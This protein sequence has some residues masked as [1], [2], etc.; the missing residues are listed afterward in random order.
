MARIQRFVAVVTLECFFGVTIGQY[1]MAETPRSAGILAQYALP[2]AG[3][4]ATAIAARTASQMVTPEEGG[5][6]M[7]DGA[8]IKIPAGAVGKPMRITISALSM[9]AMPGD[10]MANITAGAKAYRFEP[11]GTRFLKPVSVSLPFDKEI[12]GSETALSNTFTYF[13]NDTAL[14][15]ERLKRLFL[16]R[17]TAVV[18]SETTHFTDMINATLKLPEGPSPIQF[19]V[20]SIKN[21]Q[22][23]DPSAGVPKVEGLEAQSQG[24]AAFQIALRLPEGRGG[25]TPKLA[26]SYSSELPN[27]W[28]G[29]G[30]DISVPSIVI[31]TKFGLPRY[32]GTDTYVLGGDELVAVGTEGGATRYRPLKESAFQRIL[33][34]NTG[35]ENFWEVT[36][37]TGAVSEYGR[38]EGWIGPARADRSRTYTWYLTKSRDAFGNTIEYSY[39]YDID[40]AYT[41][42]SEIRYSGFEGSGAPETGAYH[43]SFS[44]ED[45][46][47]RRSDSRGTFASKLAHR[48]SGVDI[49]YENQRIRSYAP[50]YTQ[51]Q[52]GQTQLAG[53][54]ERDG[55]GN[56][57]YTYTFDYY[58]LDGYNDGYMAF[59]EEEDWQTPDSGRTLATTANSSVGGNL[60]TGLQFFI[61]LPFVGTIE[62]ASFGITGGYTYSTTSS[63][64]SLVDINGDGLPDMVWRSGSTLQSYL[65]GNGAFMNPFGVSGMGDAMDRETQNTL[66]IGTTAGI[67]AIS[68]SLNYQYTWT[69][70]NTSFTDMNADG[71]IDFVTKNGMQFGLNNGLVQPGAMSFVSTPLIMTG[72]A[73][74]QAPDPRQDSFE[75]AYYKQEP[76]RK[77]RAYRSGTVEVDQTARLM[78]GNSVSQDG[79]ALNTYSEGGV[80]AIALGSGTQNGA[81]T[82]SYNVDR[83]DPLYFHMDTGGLERGDETEWKVIIRYTSVRPFEALADCAEFFPP[84]GS[85]DQLPFN[86]NRLNPI[87]DS[88]YED[89]HWVYSLKTG[90]R[91]LADGVLAPVY[92]ALMEHACFVPR[93]ISR[94]DMDRLIAECADEPYELVSVQGE[95][96]SVPAVN[97]MLSGYRFVNETQTLYRV[98]G[99]GDALVMSQMAEEFTAEELGRIGSSRLLDGTRVVPKPAGGQYTATRHAAVTPA[100][101]TILDSDQAAVAGET[102]W[103]QGILM[104]ALWSG[105]SAPVVLETR[106]LRE[107]GGL[108]KLYIRDGNGEREQTPADLSV[109]NEGADGLVV[110]YTESGVLRTFHLSGRTSLLQAMCRAAYEGPLSGIVMADETLSTY[111]YE[112][113]PAASFAS[114]LTALAATDRTFMSS[115]YSINGDVYELNASLSTADFQ[116]VLR[117]LE[118]LAT[119]AGSLFD[120]FAGDP[121]AA[122]RFIRMTQAEYDSFMSGRDPQFSAYFDSYVENLI[123]YRYQKRDLAAADRTALHQAMYEFRRDAELFPYYTM[124]VLTG[125][126][127]LKSGLS[128]GDLVKVGNTVHGAGLSAYTGM[129][130]SLTY[131]SNI[132]LPVARTTLPDGASEESDAPRGSLA[133]V[134]AGADTCVVDLLRFDSQERTYIEP[135]YLHVFNTETDYSTQGLTRNVDL[136]V[137]DP[138]KLCNGENEI[139][140]GGVQGWYYG[141]WTGYY[142]WNASQLGKIPPKPAENQTPAP[143]Y[144]NAMDPNLQNGSA[145]ISTDGKGTGLP[146]PSDAWIGKV[147]S[148]QEPVMDDGGVTT[149]QTYTY[150]AFIGRQA[151]HASRNGGEAYYNIPVNT[152]GGASGSLPYIR[153]SSSDAVDVNGGVSVGVFGGNITFNSGSSWQYQSLMDLNGDRYPDLVDFGNCNGSFSLRPGTGSGFGPSIGM[154]TPF[155]HISFSKNSTYGFG[156]SLGSASG[157]ITTAYDDKGKPYFTTVKE[158]GAGMSMGINGTIG[159]SYQTEGFFD[160]NGD[161]LPDHVSRDGTGG[162]LVALNT[163]TAAFSS[164]ILDWGGGMTGVPNLFTSISELMTQ[165]SGLNHT[166]TGSFGAN[167]GLTVDGAVVGVGASAG[168]TATVSQTYAGLVDVNGDGLPDQVVKLKDD[169]YFRVRFNLGDCFASDTVK[170]YRPEWKNYDPNAL[171]QAVE[172]DLGT[173]GDNITGVSLPD[174]A[175][176]TDYPGGLPADSQNPVSA[177]M[178]PLRVD[179]VLNYSSGMSFNLGGSLTVRICFTLLALTIKAGV[180]GSWA[181]TSTTIQFNDI[182]GDGLPDHIMKLP[183]EQFIRVKP[184]AMGKVGLLS[185]VHLPQG[186]HYELEYARVGNT[187]DMPQSKWVLSKVT[188]DAGGT[189]PADRGADSYEVSYE[190]GNGYYSRTDREFWGFDLVRTILADQ[191]RQA[192]YYHNR[193]YATRGME[194]KREAWGSSANGPAPL[195]SMSLTDVETEPLEYYDQKGRQAMFPRPSAET[196]RLYDEASGS[197][198]ESRTRYGYTVAYGN[199]EDVWD[200]GDAAAGGDELSAHIEYADL[201]GYFKQHPASITIQG[202]SGA[203]LRK[204]EGQYGSHGELVGLTQYESPAVGRTWSIEHD[205]YGNLSSIRDPR[206]SAVSWEYDVEVH[207]HI[208]T[209]TSSNPLLGGASYSSHST[210]D[211]GLGAE[212]ERVDMTGEAMSFTYDSHARMTEVRSPYDTGSLPSV[213]YQYFTSS[214]PWYAVTQ[215]KVSF[216]PADH[217]ALST[218]ISVDGLGRVLQTAKQGEVRREGSS[219]AG[220]NVSGAVCYDA[221]E[222]TVAEGQPVFMEGAGLP[223]LATLLRPTLKAYDHL[224]RVTSIMLPGGASSA[225]SYFIRNGRQVEKTIDPKGNVAEKVI[226]A[227]GNTV[228]ANRL[229]AAEGLLTGASYEYD[230]LGQILTVLD[231]NG[232]AV[233]SA[234]DMMGRRVRLESP[235]TGIVEYEFDASGNVARKTDSVTRKRGQSIRYEYDGLNRLVKVDYPKSPD[236]LYTYGA[237][238]AEHGGAGRIIRR[239]DE[240]GSVSFR[241]GKLGE[242]V[243]EERTINRLTPLAPDETAVLSYE[244]DYLGRMQSI[245]YPDGETVS[246][247]YDYGGQV[248]SVTGSH[249]GITTPYV[250]DIGYD[251]FGQRVYIRYGNGIETSYTY[252]ANRRWLDTINT[253]TSWN[254]VYQAMSY[255]FDEVGNVMGVTNTADTYQTV[256]NY[257]Y[258]SL[259]QLT[260]AEGQ[261]TAQKFGMTDY[262]SR[263]TQDFG[264]DVIGNLTSKTST[265][266]TTPPKTI[267]AALDYKLDYSYYAGKAHQAERVGD[268]WYRYDANGNMVEERQGGHSTAPLDDAQLSLVGDVRVANRGFGLATGDPTGSH[269]YERTFTWDEENRLKRSAD[270]AATVDYRYGADGERAIKYSSNSETLYFDSLWQMTTDYPSLRQSKHVYVGET[271][272]ST[273]CNI[274]GYTDSGYETLNTYYYHPDHLGSA[275]L[276]TDYQGQKYEHLEYTPY[277]ELWVEE[278]SEPASKTPFRFTGKEMDGETGLYYFGARYMNPRTG[279]WISSDPAMESYLP[280]APLDNKARDAN[281]ELP[282]MG[283]VFNIVNLQTYH[284][285]GNNPVKYK[286]PSGKMAQVAV[287]VGAGITAAGIA[288]VAAIIVC[289]MLASLTLS[290]IIDKAREIARENR[291]QEL[292]HAFPMFLGGP[293]AQAL[294]PMERGRHRQLHKDLNTFLATYCGGMRPSSINPGAKI[295]LNFTLDE[296]INTVAKFYLVNIDQYADAAAQFFSDHPE[297]LSVENI[298]WAKDNAFGSRFLQT[299]T[300]DTGEEYLE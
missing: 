184:N 70:A 149:T 89:S 133:P 241:Y 109:A 26:L 192:V 43:V 198:T 98:G 278:T 159:S 182:D 105:G 243:R 116:R 132:A 108:W 245:T 297:A 212:T 211:Y 34:R 35:G 66:S 8:T 267:G 79:V 74:P 88:R 128:G 126:R 37:K 158:V 95:L 40:N 45:R 226:D 239:E 153:T 160:M 180:N 117:L 205:R 242:T 146:V 281:M 123:T 269:V 76:V 55:A 167:V 162:Y 259:Y 28:L 157:G 24:A 10:G 247:G 32:D 188:R 102:I 48:L 253:R 3:A 119:Q 141:M 114:I 155:D 255:S 201:P 292:H 225:L 230:A 275:Q 90:W 138:Y 164:S 235:D 42:L 11:H 36:S 177:D 151:M 139:F 18:T 53:W 299:M 59:Q 208:V 91:D 97:V 219:L 2:N 25:A 122:K 175:P 217:Q 283:G 284:Y 202:T 261:I 86:D 300:L 190:Y 296:R 265:L 80:S 240:S 143:P 228:E 165:P 93:T 29:R 71:F 273:R 266:Q 276:V 39:E 49:Y 222:R 193:E 72:A 224:D 185:A 7:L 148:Y 248:K 172:S 144:F 61:W 294:V 69:D 231:R 129:Q 62:L 65:N 156:A 244:S 179:D 19:D 131:G 186:G 135:R 50:S 221:K 246:Y 270:A 271:R 83:N 256:Y 30:F 166:S 187:V 207:S 204:R 169:P 22:A 23:A 84:S 206:G 92:D 236:V 176:A 203:L 264:F 195:L 215:N 4:Q 145:A 99:T 41:Y 174:G 194:W 27:G 285:S 288:T 214:A 51:N 229:D 220:W 113:I 140:H 274:K 1:C 54:T 257:S 258:D 150:A 183:F 251:E 67:A 52:F 110:L 127:T 291:Y 216:D 118:P 196:R 197:Y 233:R 13:Y 199:V 263:Y 87:Y 286:D 178:N 213:S 249:Y 57:F 120:R 38:G 21:L 101:A 250:Q 104:D 16:D 280:V 103:D 94:A 124:D 60:Y 44:R 147:S 209:S 106:W 289:G 15:W 47:D 142:E 20:N 100:P 17:E 252:D 238:G 268:M 227:R 168:F 210:W 163:G 9:T 262:T 63:L 136:N 75:K 260:H 137:V 279:V 64:G 81:S 295:Q 73:G 77:W 290:K 33:H 12:T 232:N 293:P 78:N 237:S 5:T 68:G 111:C 14:R 189:L 58:A 107:E 6:L 96:R 254:A 173:I 85:T 191:S 154:S 134:P 277:G 223:G 130:R 46:P 152:T 287:G 31:D 161:G 272:I 115:C 200:D 82:A 112:E 298:Q 218:V 171:R 282:G 121:A 170:L 125:V 181:S 56:P 234:Y